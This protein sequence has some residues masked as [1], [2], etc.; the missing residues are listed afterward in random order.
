MPPQS[1]QRRERAKPA[2]GAYSLLRPFYPTVRFHV[3][4]KGGEKVG[5]IR[6]FQNV[7][8]LRSL[9][10]PL[11]Y[12]TTLFKVNNL[13]LP[14]TAAEA[15]LLIIEYGGADAKGELSFDDFDC[16]IRGQ[17]GKNARQ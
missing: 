9:L 4:F 1:N 2:P 12:V 7:I 11:T 16:L 14:V 15:R 5:S 17:T 8:V 3:L 13:G 10:I 6:S